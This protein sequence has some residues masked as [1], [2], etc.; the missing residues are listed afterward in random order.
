VSTLFVAV[1][2]TTSLVVL[3]LSVAG[4][5]FEV[6]PPPHDAN[7]TIRPPKINF[8]PLFIVLDTI[9]IGLM[10]INQ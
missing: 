6:A 3:T 7:K 10:F 5:S 9:N 8:F 1:E 4:T 2:S